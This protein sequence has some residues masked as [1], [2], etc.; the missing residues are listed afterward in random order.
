MRIA[1]HPTL[2]GIDADALARIEQLATR[3]QL[4]TGAI[5]F[6]PGQACG[7]LPLVLEGRIRVRMT[8]CSGHEIVLYRI[9]AAD[10]C[11]LSIGCLMGDR[12][13]RAEAIVERPTTA[14]I[15]PRSLFDDLFDRCP[16]F[17]RHIMHAFGE[18]LDRL[19]TRIEDVAFA[20]MDTRLAEW[21]NERPGPPTLAVTHQ[22]IAA[23]LG[24]AREV[25]SRLLKY[26]ERRGW[27][28][29][30]RGAVERLGRIPF[31]LPGSP[32]APCEQ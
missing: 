29:L 11:T 22:D 19:L 20:R 28:R 7:G 12:G 25:V 1:E 4:E 31:D 23:E 14:L 15:L 26:F 32:R 6:R 10:L 17:R 21:L 30:R 27:L 24:T 9:G 13:Y 8:G 16:D 3:L 5:V 2:A 18:R